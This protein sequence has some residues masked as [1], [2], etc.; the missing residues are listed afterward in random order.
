[1]GGVT[2]EV[3]LDALVGP[4]GDRRGKLQVTPPRVR[5]RGKGL[6]FHAH[7]SDEALFI[8]DAPIAVV[9]RGNRSTGEAYTATAY[10][11]EAFPYLL[12]KL[13]AFA[14]RKADQNKELGRHHALDAYTIVGMMTEAEYD[15]AQALA[16]RS[17]SD[18]HFVRVC[19]IVAAEFTSPT[20]L[21]ILRLRE[22]RLFRDE[23][24]LDEFAATLAEIFSR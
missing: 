4:L 23:F 18:P 15:R 9:L 10:V 2:Q 14:D 8:E 3:K 1:V 17:R 21:G 6:G 22:H 11:P 24:R 12:M 20:A 16:A 19:D 7:Q 13:S 5:P